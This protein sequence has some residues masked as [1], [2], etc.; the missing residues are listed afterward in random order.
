MHVQEILEHLKP[1]EQIALIVSDLK[2]YRNLAKLINGKSQK[3][4]LSENADGWYKVDADLIFK[5][6]DS[7]TSFS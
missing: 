5:R 3:A 2:L 6:P 4:E 1:Q 7:L